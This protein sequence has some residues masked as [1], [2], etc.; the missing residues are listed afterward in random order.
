[1]LRALAIAV[2]VSTAAGCPKPHARG[3]RFPA[4]DA[5]LRLADDD[6]RALERDRFDAMAS[7]DPGRRALRGALVT[8]IAA[9]IDDELTRGRLRRAHVHVLELLALFR[10]DPDRIAAEAGPGIKSLLRAR[11]AFGRAGFDDAALAV[12]VFLAE[13]DPARR[14]ERIAELDEVLAFT[15][16]LARAQGGEH[17][18]RARSI[19]ALESI[20]HRLP[21]AWLAD[22]WIDL[23]VARAKAVNDLLSSSPDIDT[24]RESLGMHV[25]VIDA[26]HQVA[27]ALVRTHRASDVAAKLA[28]L[29][30]I[31]S[32]PTLREAAAKLAPTSA[33]WVDFAKR[34]R[35]GHR[36]DESG[37][38]DP[39]AALAACRDALAILPRDGALIAAAA[40]HAVA[41][42][43]PG[44]AT[45]MLIAL[46][47]DGAEDA[48]AAELLAGLL[49]DRIGELAFGGRLN[50]ARATHKKLVITLDTLKGRVP[51]D[52][53]QRW[54]RDGDVVLGRGLVAQGLLDEAERLLAP[55]VKRAPAA[56]ALEALGAIAS[57]RGRSVDARGHYEA[58]IQLPG[59]GVG[60]QIA[61]GR[62]HRLAGDASAAAGDLARA[63][64]HYFA[65][66]AIWTELGGDDAPDLPPA[67]TGQRLVETGRALWSIGEV[68]K[69]IDVFEAAMTVDPDGEETHVQVVA[70]LVLGGQVG[71]AAE[72]FHRAVGAEAIGDEAKVYMALWLLGEQRRTGVT[73]DST[74]VDYLASRTAATWPD[75]LARAATGRLDLPA[76]TAAARS[77]IQRAELAFYTAT[78]ELGRP[79]AAQ[80][81]RLLEQVVQ[82]E[83]VLVFEHQ[84]ARARLATP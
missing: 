76:L 62:L 71:A 27:G 45:A 52:S 53:I 44:L 29:D 13:A 63:R 19:P 81:R 17:A 15:D 74:A 77:P 43:R 10:D 4:E 50:A 47:A 84:A 82:A 54:K 39:G 3:P 5:P 75:E 9:R 80:V 35:A 32:E 16:D 31:G 72:A 41:A 38:D 48:A 28:L 40:D 67:Q 60:A 8:A 46:F 7:D 33:S 1:V 6:D 56:D 51:L 2:L 37:D 64:S 14:A 73:P 23:I 24:V 11:D 78:L 70:F 36:T 25:D 57:E 12:L 49:R 79:P 69:A 65:A 18:V 20:V 66:F 21:V 59:E 26:A 42:G 58:A 61:R 83:L 55:I 34:L 22:R 30:G 68:E